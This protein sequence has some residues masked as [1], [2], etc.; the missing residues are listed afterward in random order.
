MSAIAFVKTGQRDTLYQ[1]TVALWKALVFGMGQIDDKTQWHGAVIF[2]PQNAHVARF[3]QAADRARNAG[4]H[5]LAMA[6]DIGSVICHEL[7]AE[8]NQLQ[9]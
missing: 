5:L 8:G 9:G 2:D 6:G 3:D 1:M 7:G 4:D